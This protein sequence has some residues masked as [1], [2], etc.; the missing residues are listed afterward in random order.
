MITA[1]E[2]EVIFKNAY[3]LEHD[4]FIDS[5]FLGEPYFLYDHLIYD[6]SEIISICGY[7][8][9]QNNIDFVDLIE[10][11]FTFFK[12]RVIFY[13][14]PAY[15]IENILNRGYSLLKIAEQQPFQYDT[16]IDLQN[17][18]PK[19]KAKFIISEILPKTDFTCQISSDT[20]LTHQQIALIK[21]YIKRTELD[22]LNKEFVL[23]LPLVIRSENIKIFNIFKDNLLQAFFVIDE[24]LPK[25][26]AYVYGFRKTEAD[27]ASDF[28]MSNAIQYYRKKGYRKFLTGISDT[29]GI[30]RF[31]KKWGCK[32]ISDPIQIFTISQDKNIDFSHWLIKF[33]KKHQISNSKFIENGKK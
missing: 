23:A 15:D 27:Y 17:W 30:L 5:I 2:K 20:I 24:F 19:S 8:L 3:S 26:P 28:F 7:P 22:D 16:Y 33:Y 10:N 13:W 31:K 18:S 4:F 1:L 32:L 9:N 14:G 29:P 12:N 25:Q 11:I 21:E 6:D